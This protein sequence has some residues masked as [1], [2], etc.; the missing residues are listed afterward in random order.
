MKPTPPGGGRADFSLYFGDSP[1]ASGWWRWGGE[2]GDLVAENLEHQRG[3]LHAVLGLEGEAAVLLGVLLVEAAQV[4]Q[5]L[6]HFGVEQAAAGRGVPAADVGL[7]GVRQAI[8][9]GL[10]QRGVLHAG[11]VWGR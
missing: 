11:A 5:F 6:D 9:D 8:L 10:H 1:R 4:G 7:Q 2:S 3:E